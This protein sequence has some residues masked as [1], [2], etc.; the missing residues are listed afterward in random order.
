M[1]DW[2]LTLD[3]DDRVVVGKDIQKVELDG[4]SG[5]RRAALWEAGF[6]KCEAIFQMGALA[7]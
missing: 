1:R 4:P 6:M 5:C 7:A 2:I 3:K